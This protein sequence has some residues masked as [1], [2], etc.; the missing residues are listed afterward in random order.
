MLGVHV[1]GLILVPHIWELLAC[2]KFNFLYFLESVDPFL[3]QGI[4]FR[5][6][7]HLSRRRLP[8]SSSSHR[9]LLLLLLLFLLSPI[10]CKYHHSP[11]VV[12]QSHTQ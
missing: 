10:I 2:L 9:Y 11:S 1:G 6:Y 4:R 12:G 3:S 7:H 8:W 5:R